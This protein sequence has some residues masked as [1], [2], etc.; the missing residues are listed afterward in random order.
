MGSFIKISEDNGVTWTDPIRVPVTAPHGP[1]ICSDG[2]LIYMGNLMDGKRREERPPVSVFTSRDGGYTWEFTGSVP[3]GDVVT[4]INMYEPHVVE[5]PNGRLL[6]AIRTHSVDIDP[7]FTV[8]TTYSDDKGKTWSKPMG[9][10]VDGSPPHLLV[11][12]SGAVICSYSCRTDG[13]RCE[14]ACVSY[15]NGET[16]AEDYA[17]DHRF[18]HQK[19]MGYPATVELSDGSLLTVYYQ[20][21]P[22]EWWTSVLYTKWRLKK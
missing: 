16:W 13:E 18:G 10:G 6:G 4:P 1:T 12:S 21:W 14:R 7:Q 11:H 22:G 19:D 20:A 9:I 3:N 15:D 8:F 17:L 2:T 5:L